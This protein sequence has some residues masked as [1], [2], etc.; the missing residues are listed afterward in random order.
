MITLREVYTSLLSGNIE[1]AMSDESVKMINDTTMYLLNSAAVLYT[2]IENADLII[3]ISNILYNN[4]SLEKL[5]LEDGVY[6]LLLEWY[7]KYN[8][9][10]QV[11][12]EIVNYRLPLGNEKDIPLLNALVR[13]PKGDNL[14]YTDQLFDISKDWYEPPYESSHKKITNRQVNTSHKYPELVGTLDKCKFVLDRQ[15]I[16]AG[17]YEDQN[18]KIFERDFMAPVIQSGIV[19]PYDMSLISE[20]KYDGVSLEA[21]ISDRIISART[22]G[23]LENNLGTDL[24]DIFYGYRFPMNVD[25]KDVFGAKFEVIVTKYDLHRLAMNTGKIYK[26]SR[27]AVAGILGQGNA[28]DYLEYLT[29]VPLATS[30]P[31]EN[32]IEEVIFINKYIATKEQ[33]R[34]VL[35]RGDLTRCMFEVNKFAE[36][37]ANSRDRMPFAYDGIV[38]SFTDPYIVKTLGRKNHI[39]KYSIAVKFNPDTKYTR[40]RGYTY[41]IGQNGVIT[42]MIMFDPVEF[43]GTIHYKSSGH[44]YERFKQLNLKYNDILEVKYVND[45]MPYATRANVPEN[46]T[47]PNPIEQF[48]NVCPECGSDLF[49]S[50]S[51]KSISCMNPTCKGKRISRITNLLDKIGFKDF[52]EST[53]IRLDLKSFKDIMTQDPTRVVQALGEANGR[54]FID[55]V[56]NLKIDKIKDYILVGSLGFTN[57]SI[58]TWK[59]IL[60]E[61]PLEKILYSDDIG[62]AQLLTNIKGIG[63]LIAETIVR[64]RRAFADDLI[65]ISTMNN[66][67]SSYGDEEAKRVCFSGF[68]D[69]DLEDYLRSIGFEP[70]ESLTKKTRFLVVPYR[71]FSSSKTIKANKYGIPIYTPEFVR[72]RTRW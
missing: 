17:V 70:S 48:P 43:N 32:R 53:V 22:R 18:V 14:L 24:T 35:I 15:A 63:D 58:L 33:L 39:N 47:N 19:N 60:R 8:P 46:D 49:V 68:R 55:Q 40:F 71:D 23:D 56:E 27:T 37:A 41:T 21:E 72:N 54:K 51:G 2:D 50:I 38:V 52:A 10:F 16:D 12:S 26:N 62:L 36:E 25:V 20:L 45:V 61:V 6:D 9:N 31:F 3:R 1:L 29:L 30:L 4:T 64:E 34:Y 11:G 28:R 44:S 42:P 59:N 57:I 5:P 65:F 67:E 7:K 66:V 13:A 69:S